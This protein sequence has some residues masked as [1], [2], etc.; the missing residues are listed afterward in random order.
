MK[1]LFLALSATLI[2]AGCATTTGG[3]ARTSVSTFDGAKTVAVSPHGIA[4]LNVYV[5]CASAGFAWS[6]KNPDQ[7]SMLV[8]IEEIANGGSYHALSAV[9]LNID[10]DIVSLK[11]L[12][13][14]SNKFDFNTTYKETSRLYSTPLT[15]LERVKA[16]TST[17]IQI[18]AEGAIIEGDFKNSADSTKAYHAMLRFLDEVKA[19][20]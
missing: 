13:G 1:K 15:L 11:P 16:S 4:C 12:L 9:K 5:T 18:I 2:L 8:K 20:Q 14:D 10:G 3:S 19:N 17:K 7:A 6:D